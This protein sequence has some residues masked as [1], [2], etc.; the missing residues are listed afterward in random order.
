MAEV[1]DDSEDHPSRELSGDVQEDDFGVD[2]TREEQELSSLALLLLVYLKGVLNVE[3]LAAANLTLVS[4]FFY[5][6]YFQRFKG[7]LAVAG[8]AII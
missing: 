1:D 2:S 7:D 4:F 5:Y 3:P 8:S 6:N